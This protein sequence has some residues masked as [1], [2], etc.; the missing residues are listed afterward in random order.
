[1]SNLENLRARQEIIQN[2]IQTIRLKIQKQ[3]DRVHGEEMMLHDLETELK[4]ITTKMLD[5]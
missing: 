2:S 5:L 3:K 1:M 4:N